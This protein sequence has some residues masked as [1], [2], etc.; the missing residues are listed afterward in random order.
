VHKKKLRKLKLH[1]LGDLSVLHELAAQ[2]PN[3]EWLYLPSYHLPSNAIHPVP[4]TKDDWLQ[5]LPCFPNLQVFRGGALWR[6]VNG[7]KQE[8][9]E[10]LKEI[11]LTCPRLREVDHCDFYEK[12][13]APKRIT[14][15]REGEEG[16][17]FSYTVTKPLPR[18][19]FD[20]VDGTFD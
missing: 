7:E 10:M 5:L 8:L 2:F 14:F 18:D 19:A 1:S 11:M 9:H 6:A 16:E 13:D 20:V 15:K 4:I 17:K 3:I 12:H